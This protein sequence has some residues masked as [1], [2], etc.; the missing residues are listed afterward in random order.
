[1]KSKITALGTHNT[2]MIKSFEQVLFETDK[3]SYMKQANAMAKDL[4]TFELLILEDVGNNQEKLTTQIE[5]MLEKIA[6][7]EKYLIHE[8]II[9][10]EGYLDTYSRLHDIKRT[11]KY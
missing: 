5:N 1:M 7:L 6:K 8:L 2:S 11:I 9:D 3:Y 4:E 10:N